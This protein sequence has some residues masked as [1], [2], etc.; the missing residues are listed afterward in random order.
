MKSLRLYVQQNRDKLWRNKFPKLN[1]V[2]ICICIIFNIYHNGG[3]CVFVPWAMTVQII[4]FINIITFTWVEN[5]RFWQLNALVCG[6]STGVFFYWIVFMGWAVVLFAAPVW[7]IFLLL[8]RNVIH[9]IRKYVRAWYFAGIILCVI[10]AV[11]STLLFSSAAQ[12]VRMGKYD[13]KNPMT[14]RILGMH[15]RYHTRICSYDGWRPPLHDPA[16]IIGMRLTGGKDPLE[17]MPLK[18][19]VVL[20]HKVYPSH[21]VKAR[22]ACSIES[23]QYGYFDDELWEGIE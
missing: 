11:N 6:I 18:N 1:I 21:P 15:F 10:L 12:K 16:M 8:W 13:T 14:E 20:Y 4:C 23:M 22:C 17:G 9:P 2:L 3:F 5:T 19:R 7:F